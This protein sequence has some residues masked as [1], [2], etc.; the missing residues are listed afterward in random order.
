MR[1]LFVHHNSFVLL[2]FLCY[3]YK[4]IYKLTPK[5]EREKKKE[6]CRQRLMSRDLRESI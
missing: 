4:N 5:R 6:G 2:I 1:N 3:L